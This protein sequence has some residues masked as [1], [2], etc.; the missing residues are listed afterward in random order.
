MGQ[1]YALLPRLRIE[2][3]IYECVEKNVR[4]QQHLAVGTRVHTKHTKIDGK[5]RDPVIFI[6]LRN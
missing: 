5:L 3:R 4:G 2:N 6:I 1:M